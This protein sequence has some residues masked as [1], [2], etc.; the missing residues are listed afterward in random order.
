MLRIALFFHNIQND[1]K[2]VAGIFSD[3]ALTPASEIIVITPAMHRV[4]TYTE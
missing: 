2:G 1:E 3:D 4:K